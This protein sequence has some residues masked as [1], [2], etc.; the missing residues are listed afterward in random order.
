M[1]QFRFARFVELQVR[2]LEIGIIAALALRW[3]DAIASF[4]Y[5]MPFPHAVYEAAIGFSL[6]AVLLLLLATLWY[7]FHGPASRGGPRHAHQYLY[8]GRISL[9]VPN[10]G[11][12][13]FAAT[14]CRSRLSCVS[15]RP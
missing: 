6:L 4:F 3:F 14:F 12:G 8:R 15:L 9:A 7:L 10:D 5:K 11:I 13:L 1:E 2:V